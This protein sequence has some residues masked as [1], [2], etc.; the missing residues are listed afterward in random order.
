MPTYWKSQAETKG[1][2]STSASA[3]NIAGTQIAGE[4]GMAWHGMAAV[5]RRTH[6]QVVGCTLLCHRFEPPRIAGLWPVGR[7]HLLLPALMFI[8]V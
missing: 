5:A 1:N 2:G 4:N 6:M 7:M 8:M 3:G